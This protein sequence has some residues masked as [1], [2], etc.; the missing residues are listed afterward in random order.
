L[1]QKDGISA[2]TIENVNAQPGDK[3]SGIVKPDVIL[4]GQPSAG[5]L[6]PNQSWIKD[7]SFMAFRE[8][9]Q[10]VPEF[11]HF[12]DESAKKLQN[13]NVSGDFIGARI[14]GRWKSG[15]ILPLISNQIFRSAKRGYLKHSTF[16]KWLVF[17]F[18]FRCPAYLGPGPRQTGIKSRARF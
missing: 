17:F 11:Q 16:L 9:Q 3:K 10:L 4:L 15:E 13:P 7:G 1:L 14:V 2:P 5:N 12:C 6:D 8:L 18:G